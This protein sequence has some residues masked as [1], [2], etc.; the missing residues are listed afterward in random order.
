MPRIEWKIDL[1][2]IATLIIALVSVAVSYS[3]TQ[4]DVVRLDKEVAAL[5]AADEKIE[6]R[7]EPEIRRLTEEISKLREQLARMEGRSEARH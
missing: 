4:A 3:K 7:L 1:G 2:L 5:Q 6:G